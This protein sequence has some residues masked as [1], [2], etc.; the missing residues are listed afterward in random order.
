[1]YDDDIG[2][3][4]GIWLIVAAFFIFLFSLAAL[5]TEHED[6]EPVRPKHPQ[7]AVDP[8]V[9][10]YNEQVEAWDD[11]L[12]DHDGYNVGCVVPDESLITKDEEPK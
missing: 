8:N 6:D 1:M 2:I 12:D 5:T 7:E 10:E 11:C 4:L 9:V 3:F